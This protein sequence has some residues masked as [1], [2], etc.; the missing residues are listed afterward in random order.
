MLFGGTVYTFSI[1]LSVFLL[2][3]GI[4]SVVCSYLVRHVRDPLKALEACQV[5]LVIGIA[6]SAYMIGSSLP[7]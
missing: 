5:L 7:Y 2:R 6:W 1:I 3:L 4:C